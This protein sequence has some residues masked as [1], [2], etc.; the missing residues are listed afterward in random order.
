MPVFKP[1][2]PIHIA[3]ALEQWMKETGTERRVRA[4]NVILEWELIIGTKLAQAAKPVS[5]VSG[6]LTVKAKNTVWRAEL[7]MRRSEIE[8]KVNDYFKE[9]IVKKVIVK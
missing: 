8:K 6:I 1:S 4:Q 9:E 5:I 7:M 2:E 3:K